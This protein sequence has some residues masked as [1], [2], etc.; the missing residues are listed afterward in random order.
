MSSGGGGGGGGVHT[1]KASNYILGQSVGG[2]GSH[3]RGKQ[4]YIYILGQSVCVGGGGGGG[5]QKQGEYWSV[6]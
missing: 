2:V 4:P 1:S 5:V 3:K 6:K